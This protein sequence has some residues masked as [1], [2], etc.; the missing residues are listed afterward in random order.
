MR[1]SALRIA[2]H[3]VLRRMQQAPVRKGRK[4]ATAG[5]AAAPASSRKQGQFAKVTAAAAS[6]AKGT[7]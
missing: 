6:L 2:H 4:T 1:D 3:D 5:G 7:G